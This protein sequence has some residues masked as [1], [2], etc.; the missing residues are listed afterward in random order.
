MG[1]MAETIVT[2]IEGNPDVDFVYFHRINERQYVLDTRDIRKE[3]EGISI[4]HPEVISLIRDNLISGL[5]E[6]AAD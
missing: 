1:N 6:I 5:A 3:L 2:L 4:N